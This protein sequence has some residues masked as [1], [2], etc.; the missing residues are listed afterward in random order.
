MY[1]VG[2]DLGGTNIA[3]AVINDNLDIIGRGQRK[4]NAP[5]PAE[6]IFADIAAAVHESVS[7]SILALCE[8]VPGCADRGGHRAG[9]PVLLS[10]HI[11]DL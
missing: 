9:L 3:V 11:G 8:G 7:D 5:R 1:K 6:E 2:V 4:T 10:G